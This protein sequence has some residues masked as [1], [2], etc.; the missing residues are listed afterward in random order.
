MDKQLND[1]QLGQAGHATWTCSIDMAG[2]M[3][4][5]HGHEA[6]IFSM[7]MQQG[8]AAYLISKSSNFL[9]VH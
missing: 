1:I 4:M 5:Q 9:L 6:Q 7:N 2:G 3:D 8:N